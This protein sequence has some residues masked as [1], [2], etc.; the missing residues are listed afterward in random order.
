MTSPLMSPASNTTGLS[1]DIRDLRKQ[2]GQTKALNGL[3]FAIGPGETH[4][5]LGE[6]GAGKSTLVK[7]LSGLIQPDSGELQLAGERA[8]IG[9]PRMAHQ[10]GIRT[11]FQ[12]VSLVKDLTVAE[13]FLLMEEPL[14]WFGMVRRRMAEE[15]VR[16]T[17]IELGLTQIDP[18]ARVEKLDLPTRQKLE[19]ARAVSRSPK[20]LLLDE[21]TASL[22][23]TDVIWLGDMI[24]RVREK[25]TTI[26]LISHRMQDVRDFCSKLTVLRNGVAVGTHDVTALSDE[27]VIELM[28]GR[29]LEAVF[30][31]KPEGPGAQAAP[32]FE[33]REYATRG[34]GPLSFTLPAGRITGVAGL[35][36]MGQRELFLGLFGAM[37]KLAGEVLVKGEARPLASPADAIDAGIS[38][39]PEER[40]SEGL[41]LDLDGKQN[42]TLATLD[43]FAKAGL[44]DGTAEQNVALSFFQ[45]VN[46]NTRATWAPVRHLSGGNQ[47][48]VIFAKWLMTGGPILL[49]YDPTRGVDVGTKAEI[50]KI[51][52][53][54]VASGGAAL[55]YS[56]DITELVNLCDDVIVLYRG[57][58]ARVLGGAEVSETNIMQAAVGHATGRP[59]GHERSLH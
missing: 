28:I 4:A 29:S 5:V 43:S 24:Q 13:N 25:G 42:A 54:Y 15:K 16:A 32:A 19:I 9:N 58:I 35:Q 18:R 10:L 38:L 46:L 56:T 2:F 3:S 48:K 8:V 26:I 31:D 45:R 30:P 41:F 12:E 36:G 47:Q 53:D 22:L 11:A 37:P 27:E 17:L 23:A 6:N 59:A 14:G 40:K 55:F 20:L 34:V 21:P 7:M 52:R 39:I 57:Q 33:A 49:L 51:M 1:L 44:L 50:Y